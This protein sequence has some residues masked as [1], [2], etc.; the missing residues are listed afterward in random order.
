LYIKNK[1]K[2]DKKMKKFLLFLM[3]FGLVQAH[4]NL[5]FS[6]GFDGDIREKSNLVF[7]GGYVDRQM[8]HDFGYYYGSYID[9]QVFKSVNDKWT[10]APYAVISRSDS[11]NL[12]DEKR[13]DYGIGGG[14][15]F[16]YGGGLSFGFYEPE[17]TFRHQ[18]FIGASLGLR[19]GSEKQF[20]ELP[21]GIYKSFQGDLF[22]CLG[23][24]FHLLKSFGLQPDILP[25]TQLQ[26]E[27]KRP[28]SSKKE[29]SWN[30]EEI[31]TSPWNKGFFEVLARQS[32]CQGF[33]SP[34]SEIQYAPKIIGLYSYSEGDRRSFFGLGAEISFR[35]EHRDNFLSLNIIYKESMKF[36]DN[37]ILVGCNFN[38][39]SLLKR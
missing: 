34:Y 9:Y 28:I 13:S 12:V 25:R 29:A 1:I 7:F 3:L 32:I 5:A 19:Y 16:E 30:E 27:Y 4:F 21:N 2:K 11:K 20:N 39:S 22:L 17:F 6:Q 23:F 31:L 24:N 15:T 14:R 26:V 36:T 35:R 18:A 38:L 10:I 37:Y 33:I 8:S